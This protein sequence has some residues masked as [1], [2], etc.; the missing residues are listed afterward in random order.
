MDARDFVPLSALLRASPAESV[1]VAPPAEPAPPPAEP[2]ASCTP[3]R[4]VLLFRAALADALDAAVARMLRELA[5]EVLAR[6]L[7]LAPC[8][9]AAIVAR[10]R[11][12][13]PVLRVRVAPADARCALDLPVVAD[14]TLEPG[15]AILELDGGALDAR[16][17]VRLACVLETCS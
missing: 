7:R 8:D 11:A 16:L 9:V 1:A 14:A 4:D 2:C 5:A 15:D 10:V 3:L 12:Q 6:E 17:G 13:M